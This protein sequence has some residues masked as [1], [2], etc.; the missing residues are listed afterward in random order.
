MQLKTSESGGIT[1]KGPEVEVAGVKYEEVQC[2]LGETGAEHDEAVDM[3]LKRL[4]DRQKSIRERLLQL[5]TS[6][7]LR[8]TLQKKADGKKKRLE[9]RRAAGIGEALKQK[10]KKRLE[11][12]E[13]LTKQLQETG[14]SVPALVHSLEPRVGNSKKQDHNK[15]RLQ[16]LQLQVAALKAKAKAAV[17]SGG[18]SAPAAKAKAAAKA[19]PKSAPAAKSGGAPAAAAKPGAKSGGTPRSETPVGL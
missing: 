10:E 8:Q 18:A 6:E 13:K 2:F 7:A 15:K 5:E 12:N 4:S 19:A 9:A 1:I 16:A 11:V 3:E 14:W 17:K